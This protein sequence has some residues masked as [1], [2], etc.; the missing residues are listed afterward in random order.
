MYSA[1]GRLEYKYTLLKG[2]NK[3]SKKNWNIRYIV[4]G[5]GIS[6]IREKVLKNIVSR[7]LRVICMHFKNQA[8]PYVFPNY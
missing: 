5:I 8:C 4:K 3:H 1:N 7:E 2:K 6:E